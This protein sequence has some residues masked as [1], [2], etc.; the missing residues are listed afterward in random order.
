LANL[1][2]GITSLVNHTDCPSGPVTDTFRVLD[3]DQNPVYSLAPAFAAPWTAATSLPATAGLLNPGSLAVA[4]VGAGTYSATYTPP[5]C[6]LGPPQ[7]RVVNPSFRLALKDGAGAERH[8]LGPHPLNLAACATCNLTAAPA[9]MN[10]CSAS[11]T[12][13]VTG[14]NLDGKTVE[15][16][17]V[18]TGGRTGSFNA[19]GAANTTFAT[20]RGAA[21]STASVTLYLGSARHGDSLEVRAYYPSKAAAQWSCGPVVVPVTSKC[22]SLQV[23]GDSGY[24]EIV[25]NVAGEQACLSRIDEL[26]FEVEDCQHLAGTLKKA[27]RVRIEASWVDPTGALVAYLDEELIDLTSYPAAASPPLTFRSAARLPVAQNPTATPFDGELT[28]PLGRT[29]NLW[30][31]Y[32]DPYDP[33]DAPDVPA[34]NPCWKSVT[35]TVPLPVCF[36]NAITSAGGAT[37]NGNFNVHWG[38]V[39]IMGNTTEPQS[40]KR[41]EKLRTGQFNGA[42]Y[43][44]SGRSD[45]LFD[46]YVGKATPGSVTTG[47]FIGMANPTPGVIDRP[48]LADGYGNY[49][50]NLPHDK[51]LEM[52]TFLDYDT[53]KS[54]AKDRGV[55]WY[56]LASGNVRNPLTRKEVSLETAL[57]MTGPGQ[58]NAYHDGQFLFVDTYGA[59]DPG[60]ATTGATIDATATASLPTHSISGSFYT[61]GILYVAGSISFGGL[62]ATTTI[63]TIDV[64]TPPEH[65]THY[66]HNSAA[67]D[68]AAAGSLPIRPDPTQSQRQIALDVHIKGAVYADGEF[69]GN[70]NPAIFGAITAERGYTGGGTPEIWY[71]YNLNVGTEND[72]LCIACCTLEIAPAAASVAQGQTLALAARKAAGRVI[73]TSSDPGVASVDPATGVVTGVAV[74]STQIK[75]T[76]GNN[77]VARATVQVTDQCLLF[78]VDPPAATVA[79]GG[80]QAFT[81]VSPPGGTAVQWF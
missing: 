74:G 38:D 62:G 59:A 77:C 7:G 30:A 54:L 29:G 6:A 55:Y 58:L 67:F 42:P 27:V 15:L 12:L 45:R 31:G 60:P 33:A 22:Q 5:N 25:G 66:N 75:A 51:M 8:A 11:T 13:T 52:I 17:V 18:G 9:T 36:P 39:V 41:I 35:L 81:A 61:E 80:T 19:A 37:W 72:Y 70:G 49:F 28:N 69:Q 57:A 10:Q 40:S 63:A 53:M 34:P 47:N 4:T 43:G 32:T 56:T 64:E 26:F 1:T 71:N 76:D 48:F 78:R 14:C 21:P 50:R 46:L 68:P 16:E 23:Y 79:T 24:T 3:C 65:E 73:W 20:L 2:T 44:G